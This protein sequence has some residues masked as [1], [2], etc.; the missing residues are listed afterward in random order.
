MGIM[1]GQVGFDEGKLFETLAKEKY[2][3]EKFTYN[4]DG[5]IKKRTLKTVSWWDTVM[6]AGGLSLVFAIVALVKT[7]SAKIP[8]WYDEQEQQEIR[9]NPGLFL[10]LGPIGWKLA[11]KKAGVAADLLGQAT[12]SLK[13][14]ADLFTY[15]NALRTNYGI[16]LP[17]ETR[18][19]QPNPDSLVTHL[20]ER[21][22][23]IDP[24]TG[25]VTVKLG[26]GK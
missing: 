1:G 21:S 10:A 12:G 18:A 14:Q 17:A 23:E 5:S 9:E 24:A 20:G 16:A 3:E 15:F 13:E 8:D 6:A 4:K 2:V 22:T 19:D 26:W 11:R 7:I 25:R